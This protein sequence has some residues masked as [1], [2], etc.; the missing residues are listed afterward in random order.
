M[1]R[2][3]MTQDV[4]QAIG[5]SQSEDQPIVPAQT[6]NGVSSSTLKQDDMLESFLSQVDEESNET[7]LEK[8]ADEIVE[9]TISQQQRN[10]H[11][12]IRSNLYSNK[13]KY[14]QEDMIEMAKDTIVHNDKS[15]KLRQ[16]LFQVKQNNRELQL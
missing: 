11:Q 2:Y 10:M 16:R 15:I 7:F 4:S 12:Q 5:T 9:D 14:S 8:K 6:S 3:L 1:Q 13:Y